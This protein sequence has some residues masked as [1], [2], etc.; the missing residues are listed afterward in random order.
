MKKLLTTKDLLLLT[1]AGAG[2]IFDEARDPLC[3]IS[4]VYEAMYGFVPRRYKRHNFMQMVYR[5]LKTGD[6]EQVVKDGQKYLRLTSA[7]KARIKR[8]FPLKRLLKRWNKQWIIVLFDVEEHARKVRDLFRAK[9]K[10][11]GF[12]MLQRSVWITPLPIGKDM[13]EF[14]ESNNLSDHAFV[15]EISHVVLGDPRALARKVWHLDKLE[16]KLLEIESKL[17]ELHKY[18]EDS[19]KVVNSSNENPYDRNEKR[20]MIGGSDSFFV[21]L[22]RGIKNKNGLKNKNDKYGE[23]SMPKPW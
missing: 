2:D 23:K 22:S 18:A 17:K 21:E 12:G 11:L 10:S 3:T 4:K 8:D 19:K 1:V 16:N 5:A 6:I 13:V 14:I 7:G 15:L 20:A 9:L